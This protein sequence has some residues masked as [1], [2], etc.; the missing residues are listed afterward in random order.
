MVM[1]RRNPGGDAPRPSL[2]AATLP[3][4]RRPPPDTAST[5]QAHAAPMAAMQ[6]HKQQHTGAPSAKRKPAAAP[7]QDSA[8]TLRKRARLAS[9]VSAALAG[10]AAGDATRRLPA[11][12]WHHVF[13]LLPPRSLGSLLA[14]SKLFH[15]YL[16]PCSAMAVEAPPP[17]ATAS[18]LAPRRPDAIWQASRRRFWPQMPAPLQGKSELDMW[19][20]CCTR[21]CQFCGARDRDHVDA[22][23]PRPLW[24]R[25]PGPKGVVPVFPFCTVSCGRCL[26]E[27]SVKV[28]APKP[29]ADGWMLC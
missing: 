20:L 1:Q 27:R 9:P 24:E 6:D 18:A 16:D 19:R 12:I 15:H 21:T 5:P 22:A 26:V 7:P 29:L 14:V 17:S 4:R 3:Q 28:C 8:G 23:T 13:T 10:P 11:E 2:E 25:G